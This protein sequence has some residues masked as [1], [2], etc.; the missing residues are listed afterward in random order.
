MDDLL[1]KIKMLY[2]SVDIY[3]FET[4]NK[5]ELANIKV[6]ASQRGDG[7]GTK[8]V[9]MLQ[10]YAHSVGKPI[11]LRPEPEKGKKK[12]LER[13]YKRL[14]FVD[15]RGRNMDYTLSTT[16]GKTMHWKFK[17]WIESVEN[18]DIGNTNNS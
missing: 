14:G 3:A 8:I 18:L 6:P 12:A 1:E 13:F 5:I 7:A 2:P 4:P 16:F 17:E 11:V 10:D 15:N 9:K